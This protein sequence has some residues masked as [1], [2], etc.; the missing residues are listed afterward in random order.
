MTFDLD[1]VKRIT[2][3]WWGAIAGVAGGAAALFPGRRVL[4]GAIAGAA[5]FG[6]ALHMTPCCDGCAGGQ[7]CGGA[8]PPT[9]PSSPP[10]VP[11]DRAAA[12]GA[13]EEITVEELFRQ[14]A[15]ARGCS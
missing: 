5:L 6:L 4:A 11:T 7:G 10:I 14:V 2:P 13:T 8:A 3:G 15:A 1:H 9:A 12:A